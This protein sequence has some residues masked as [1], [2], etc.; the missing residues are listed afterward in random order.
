MI[1]FQF[2]MLAL[3]LTVSHCIALV[4]LL[5]LLLKF[6]FSHSV[7][8]LKV[9][10]GQKQTLMS[11]GQSRPGEIKREAQL[12]YKCRPRHI[13]SLNVKSQSNAMFL[14]KEVRSRASIT[15]TMKSQSP[16]AYKSLKVN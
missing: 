7:T 8:Y 10:V 1:S 6:Q 9:S 12:F 14:V 15:I 11:R 4:R 5:Y 2:L 13:I 16:K 3:T